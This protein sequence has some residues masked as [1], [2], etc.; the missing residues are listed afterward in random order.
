MCEWATTTVTLK[1][2]PELG[3]ATTAEC[4]GAAPRRQTTAAGALWRAA[5]LR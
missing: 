4:D 1:E 3:F 5:A 2:R